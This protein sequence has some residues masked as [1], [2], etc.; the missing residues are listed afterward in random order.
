MATTVNARTSDIVD[1][2]R[3]IRERWHT[4]FESSEDAPVRSISS[5]S[6]KSTRSRT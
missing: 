2:I 3:A 1:E 4:Y 6:R 5:A